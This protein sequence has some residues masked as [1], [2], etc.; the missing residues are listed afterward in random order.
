MGNPPAMAGKGMPHGKDE[1]PS[2]L[3]RAGGG[4][5]DRTGGGFREKKKRKEA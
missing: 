5:M 3:G 1:T 2:F 4:G